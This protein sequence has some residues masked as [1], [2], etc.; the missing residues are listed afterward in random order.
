MF[1]IP[2]CERLH[3]LNRGLSPADLTSISFNQSAT[4][5][6]VTSSSGLLQ[7]YQLVKSAKQPEGKDRRFR[8]YGYLRLMK[9]ASCRFDGELDS[10]DDSKGNDRDGDEGDQGEE[11]AAGGLCGVWCGLKYLTEKVGGLFV[12][13]PIERITALGPAIS[14]EED[15]IRSDNVLSIEKDNTVPTRGG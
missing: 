4:L 2:K 8:G 14:V 12:A 15:C 11:P 9:H 6:G 1:S 3:S 13:R 7:I 10:E 5:L